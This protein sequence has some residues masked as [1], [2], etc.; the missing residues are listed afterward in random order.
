[1]SGLSRKTHRTHCPTFFEDM[2]FRTIAGQVYERKLEIQ[3]ILSFLHRTIESMF[4]SSVRDVTYVGTSICLIILPYVRFPEDHVTNTSYNRILFLCRFFYI[5]FY[6]LSPYSGG[7]D[8]SRTSLALFPAAFSLSFNLSQNHDDIVDRG[9]SR[10]LLPP[11]SPPLENAR[12]SACSTIAPTVPHEEILRWHCRGLSWTPLEGWATTR[13]P[14]S[15]SVGPRRLWAS[16][17]P[18]V[19]SFARRYDTQERDGVSSTNSTCTPSSPRG[20]ARRSLS[21]LGVWGL[22]A[23][24]AELR[25]KIMPVHTQQS[26]TPRGR[27]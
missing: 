17:G 7:K 9:P 13:R 18:A 23:L 11:I 14:L 20:F 6:F 24:G 8:R 1:M 3:A 2:L 4:V 25:R 27:G 19:A 16:S 12:R 21:G 22:L 26:N 15:F 10:P 5:E